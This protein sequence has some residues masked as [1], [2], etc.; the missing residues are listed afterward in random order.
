MVC[1][2]RRA[3]WYL[4]KKIKFFFVEKVCFK[5]IIYEYQQNFRNIFFVG[6]L[7]WIVGFFNML[8][9]DVELLNINKILEIICLLDF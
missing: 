3:I 4:Q 1:R 9:Y 8:I 5:I 7:N 6:F 2:A